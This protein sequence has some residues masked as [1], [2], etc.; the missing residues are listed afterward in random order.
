M[1]NILMRGKKVP[2]VGSVCY[3]PCNVNLDAVPECTG[4]DEVV[5]IGSQTGAR[6]GNDMQKLEYDQ[7]RGYCGMAA[8]CR[9]AILHHLTNKKLATTICMDPAQTLRKRVW[10]DWRVTRADPAGADNRG[11][12][13]AK[14]DRNS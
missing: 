8:E 7:L 3:G 1:G 14:P 12:R 13:D 6:S 4:G 11:Y 9:A 10:K 5:L 2:M